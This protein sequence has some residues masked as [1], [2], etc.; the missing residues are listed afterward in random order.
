MN[1]VF[2][3]SALA[4]LLGAGAGTAHAD[5][6][7]TKGGIKIKTD[8]GRFEASIGGRLQFDGNLVMKDDAAAFGSG[9][10]SF[11]D[12]SSFYFRRIYLTFAGKAYGWKY[13]IEPDLCGSGGVSNSDP[14]ASA[15]DIGNTCRELNFQDIYLGTDVGPGE[16]LFGQRKVFRG[17]EELTSSNE[18]TMMERP[19]ISGPLLSGRDF[20]QG[21]FYSI[22]REHYTA[23]AAVY[24]LHGSTTNATQGIGGNTRLTFAPLLTEGKTVHLGVT[25]SA[26]SVDVPSGG[27]ASSSARYFGRLGNNQSLVSASSAFDSN[28]T[29]TAEAATTFGPFFAQAEYLSSKFAGSPAAAD[30]TVDAWYVQASWFVTGETKPYKAKDAIYGNPKPKGAKGALELTLRYEDAKNGDLTS[31]TAVNELQDLIVGANWYVNPN[32]RFMLNYIMGSAERVDGQK[33]E[34]DTIAARAQFSF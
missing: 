2:K 8:D 9:S 29:W 32:V 23:S 20:A 28:D 26:E 7:E 12:R 30:Q 31:A 5:S 10:S 22:P 34:P 24:S 19:F 17:M 27:G 14:A 3:F 1:S 16:L 13:K 21:I 4:L 25:Y 18:L 6:A 33:D 15:T 11:V